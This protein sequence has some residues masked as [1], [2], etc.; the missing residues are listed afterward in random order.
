MEIKPNASITPPGEDAEADDAPDD[1]RTIA[2][3]MSP[4]NYKEVDEMCVDPLTIPCLRDALKPMGESETFL[5]G[6]TSN[7]IPSS[8]A[9]AAEPLVRTLKMPQKDKIKRNKKK[10]N[11]VVKLDADTL[12]AI[13]EVTDSISRFLVF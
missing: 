8:A 7:K 5:S 6:T 10:K 11:A 13:D 2:K 9:A 1:S 12:T 3:G 4:K